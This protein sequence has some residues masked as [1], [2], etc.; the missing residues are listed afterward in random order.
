MDSTLETIIAD[1]DGLINHFKNRLFLEI[2]KNIDSNKPIFET[3]KVL[4]DNLNLLL[5]ARISFINSRKY[6]M[7]AR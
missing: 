6:A 1:Y 5:L 7:S 3:T 2:N 4:E